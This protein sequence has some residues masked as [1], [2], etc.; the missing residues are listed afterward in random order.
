MRKKWFKKL[1]AAFCAAAIAISGMS[2]TAFAVGE[3]IEE[4]TDAEYQ[5]LA[6]LQSDVT[7]GIIN[8][9]KKISPVNA[10]GV[11]DWD[12]QLPVKDAEMAVVKVGQYATVTEIDGT[13]KTMIGIKE[14]LVKAVLPSKTGNMIHDDTNGYYYMP[15]DLYD[16]FQDAMKKAG[17]NLNNNSVVNDLIAAAE[18]VKT[19]EDG[20]ASF[21][22][23]PFGIYLVAEN[24][25]T[26]AQI[27]KDKDGTWE[28]VLF[29]KKQYPYIVSLPFSEN[30]TWTTTV[31]A[32]AK[33]EE[34]PVDV[35]KKIERNSNTL[36]G[37]MYNQFKTDVTHVGDTVEFTLTADV[38]IIEAHEEVQSYVLTDEISAGF[39]L[40]E[41]F[42]VADITIT[43]SKDQTYTLDEDYTAVL[44]TG[45][46][47]D[48][49]NGYAYANTVTITFTDSGRENIKTLA[50]DTYGNQKVY[51]SYV[52]KVNENAVV[53]PDGNHN[54][55]KLDLAAAGSGNIETGW[56]HVTEYIFTMEGTKTFDGN[57]D[58]D[59]A[60]DVKFK[61]YLDEE[62]TKGVVL[63]GDNGVYTYDGET[64]PGEATEI[65]LSN[66][67][68]FSV[69]GVP[70]YNETTNTSDN[71]YQ[72]TLYLKETATAAGYNKLAKVIPITL[73]ANQDVNKAY[74]GRLSEGK[75]NEV[76]AT[77]NVNKDG[78]TFT[79]NN[80]SGF[81]LPS[82]GG[83]GIW[84][85][86]VGGILVIAFGIF[87]YRRSKK[88]A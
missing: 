69:K 67:S 9:E 76:N 7:T 58:N 78:I 39:T 42:T 19:E 28:N 49:D 33:N 1:G 36:T 15:Y 86:V 64:T 23:L 80:T 40:P 5:N 34:S 74:D 46:T 14:N 45:A 70:V 60:A 32:K 47:T 88:S 54:R 61:L 17:N 11:G 10:S 21:D 62:C 35:D 3:K 38:P 73:T 4:F 31:N 84:M 85:F 12:T 37:E 79:V 55:V 48:N 29:S 53:G 44:K 68:T 6:G 52:A 20:I 66:T 41:T 26:A 22:S 57:Q 18:K 27:D 43:D 65:S 25:V 59:N 24:S 51:V 8:V 87:Y 81:Q 83:M 72:A 30:G 63:T 75:V 50:H 56:K 82:T 16:D 71:V 77:L 2:L 13:V